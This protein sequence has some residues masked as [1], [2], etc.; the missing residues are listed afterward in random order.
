MEERRSNDKFV[1]TNF[2]WLIR[3]GVIRGINNFKIANVHHCLLCSS[4][5]MD[6]TRVH[7][8]NNVFNP[9]VTSVCL[10]C[11]VVGSFLTKDDENDEED[12]EDDEDTT[13]DSDSS[14]GSEEYV[15]RVTVPPV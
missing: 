13:V 4:K 3:V 2:S 1:K 5:V 10:P 8:S 12:D 9:L 6:V 15:R 7:L 11:T 14:D